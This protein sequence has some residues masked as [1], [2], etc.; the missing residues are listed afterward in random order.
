M[1]IYLYHVNDI[2]VKNYIKKHNLKGKIFE[3]LKNNKRL[4]TEAK[5]RI[6]HPE[7]LLFDEGVAGARRA[8]NALLHIPNNPKSTTVKWDGTPAI[9][10]GR[11]E[12]G[13]VIGGGSA[14]DG[15]VYFDS[16]GSVIFD[17][18]NSGANTDWVIF[19]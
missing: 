6:D 8:I 12:N 17:N 10:F 7:D 15:V 2:G 13:F 3:I 1:F 11:D 5:A 18:P 14:L 16:N 4:L 9:I 19:N